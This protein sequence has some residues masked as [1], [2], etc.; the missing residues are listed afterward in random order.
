MRRAIP[1]FA[2]LIALSQTAAAGVPLFGHVSCTVV[3]FYVAKYSEAA[4]EKWAR[5]QGYSDS[6]I[7][8]ARRCLHSTNV[9]TA[10]AATSSQ[11]H[12]HVTEQERAPQEPAEREPNQE[13]PHVVAMQVQRADAE[14]V[15]Q[16]NQPGVNGSIRSK[17]VEDRSAGDVSQK[18]KDLAPS[19]RK[20]TTPRP[21]YAAAMH[22]AGTGH[23]SWLKRLWDHL[24]RLRQFSVAVL[25]FGGGRR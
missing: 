5:G 9:Q 17:D 11:V 19:D 18:I 23:M 16:E 3:R 13:T 20:I 2:I 14:Q 15:N 10:S 24:T 12:T 8:T 6:E 1:A 4:A 7:E 22:R 21:R 25:H